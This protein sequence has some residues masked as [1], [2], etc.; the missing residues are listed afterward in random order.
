MKRVLSVQ[1]LS[2]LGRCSLTV[3]LPVLSAMGCECSVLPTA[4][5]STHTA[6]PTP[7]IH[8]LTGDMDAICK[9]WQTIG[10]RFDALSVG[11]LSDP[12]QAA[13]VERL[14]GHFGCLVIL[15]PAMGDHGTLYRGITR[16]HVLAMERLCRKSHILLPNITEAAMLTG[17]P[18]QEEH[19][20][21]YL[22]ELTAGLLSLGAEAVILTGVSLQPD[23]VGFFSQKANAAPFL[24]QAEKLPKSFHGTGDLFSAVVAGGIVTGKTLRQ[25]AQLAAGFVERSISATGEVTP[26]GVEFE[27]QLPWLW[28]QLQSNSQTACT[29][30]CPGF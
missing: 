19:D 22:Q 13:A 18:Y 4:L 28:Q 1:S 6:F 25:A 3:A 29:N 26:Y 15:D 10:T 7:H 16:E 12:A 27:T 21:A 24:Y 20:P 11:Y 17:L 14:I 9:H 5:L 2:C 23:S 8:S 30:L